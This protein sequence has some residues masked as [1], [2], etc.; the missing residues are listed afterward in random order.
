MKASKLPALDADRYAQVVAPALKVAA[1]LAAR[2]GDPH[3]FNDMAAMLTLRR[4]VEILARCA[5]AGTAEDPA[6]TMAPQA[7]CVMP[8]Q[9]GKLPPEAVNDCL[10]ALENAS[11]LLEAAGAFSSGE[12]DTV[13]AWQAVK[14]DDMDTAHE[15]LKRGAGAMVAAVDEWEKN[16]GQ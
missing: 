16:R 8:L 12:V 7:A 14:S 13:K 15:L 10:Q 9:E 2:R 11:E 4:Q 3:L 5:N 1:D 6:L